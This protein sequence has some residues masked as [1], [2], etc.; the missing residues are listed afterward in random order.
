ML[1]VL[2][3]VDEERTIVVDWL[4]AH[5]DE[6]DAVAL[7]VRVGDGQP[8][9]F[10]DD[11]AAELMWSAVTQR[12]CDVV[13]RRGP[14]IEVIEAKVHA[15]VDAVTQVKRYVQLFRQEHRDV[16]LV[17]PRIICRKADLAVSVALYGAGGAVVQV[18]APAAAPPGR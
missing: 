1:E 8:A 3:S 2:T 10:L 12:R 17:T 5:G 16:G 6:Y 4:R 14:D 9:G 7:Q 18:V 11:A 13:A 15:H